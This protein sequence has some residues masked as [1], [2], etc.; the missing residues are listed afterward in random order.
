VVRSGP[1]VEPPELA[2][3]DAGR[4]L[5]KPGSPSRVP[6]IPN[7][8][9][10]LAIHSF[11]GGGR[12]AAADHAGFVQRIQDY[13]DKALKEAKLRSSWINP[14]E[15]HDRAVRAFVAAILDPADEN[16]FFEDFCAF[17]APVSRAGVCNSLSQLLLKIASPGVPDFYQGAE[18]WDF[19]LVDPDNRRAVDFAQRPLILRRGDRGSQ[20]SGSASGREQ[21]LWR[22]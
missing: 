5:G 11:G 1:A 13:M 17:V 8:R 16:T 7:A 14:N 4:R 10:G 22:I 18:S 3:K 12:L 6:S 9:R 21:Q 15:K 20:R 19:S 2:A